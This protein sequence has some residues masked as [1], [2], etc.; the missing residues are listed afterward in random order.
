MNIDFYDVIYELALLFAIGYLVLAILLYKGR[1]R[2]GQLLMVLA[3]IVLIYN[4]VVTTLAGF[5]IKILS[6]ELSS[7][8]G[9]ITIGLLLAS[10]VFIY[11][12][13]R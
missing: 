7:S 8:I 1:P 6:Q 10:L 3:A 13:E 2:I 5:D 9:A 4:R 11:R 12:Q